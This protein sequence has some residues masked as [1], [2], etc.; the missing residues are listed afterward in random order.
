M[1]TPIRVWDSP[2]AL[3]RALARL[4]RRQYGLVSRMQAME[5]GAS[6]SLIQRRL[7]SGR[8]ERLFTGVYR[9]AGTVPSL[10]QRLLATS[11]A[12]GEGA[13]VSY[14][15]AA[16]LWAPEGF[17]GEVL[18]I[19]V[20]RARRLTLPGVKVHRP[21]DLTRI[22]RTHH[23]RIP[24]TTPTRTL[25]DLAAVTHIDV[26]EETLDHMLRRGLTTLTR[27]RWRL[28]ELGRSGRPGIAAMRSLLDA[29]LP[30]D[31]VP[32]SPF[33]TKLLRLIRRAGLPGPVLQHEILDRG[34]F[35][36]RVDF[37]YPDVKLAIEADGHQW[38]SSRARFDRDRAR[39]NALTAMGWRVIHVTSTQ[40][41]DELDGVV[42]QIAAALAV[43]PGS[44]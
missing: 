4:A 19:S 23:A 25:I 18:E 28:G 31:P 14:R 35:V 32:E 6:R 39:L 29:R 27:L 16:L 38:H 17:T 2:E 26:V 1:N 3:D 12:A 20:P 36:A 11:L 22:D 30:S 7:D 8:W 24:V 5:A 33:E 10:Q 34:R 44:R 40:M 43:P 37:A 13:V 15:A 21:R 41:R 42:A 9:L